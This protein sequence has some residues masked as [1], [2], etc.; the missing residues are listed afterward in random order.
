MMFDAKIGMFHLVF[1]NRDDDY[2]TSSYLKTDFLSYLKLNLFNDGFRYLCFINKSSVISS[3][4]DYQM[5]MTGSLTDEMMKEEPEKKGFFWP[6]GSKKDKKPKTEEIKE[7]SYDS[8]TTLDVNKDTLCRYFINLLDRMGDQTGYAVVCPLDIFSACCEYSNELVEALISR[9]KRSNQN[10]IVLTGSVNAADHD[11]M[12]SG[13]ALSDQPRHYSVFHNENLFPNIRNYIRSKTNR[14]GFPILPKLIITYEFLKDAFGER[15][16][17]LNE[18]SYAS[19]CSLVKYSL[20]RKREI[21][22]IGYP[23]DCYAAL[24]YSWYANV[25]FREKYADLQL[26]DNPF[27]EM[28]VIAKAIGDPRFFEN[29]KEV[30][31]KEGV[32]KSRSSAQELADYWSGDRQETAI[33]YDAA[34]MN[35]RLPDIYGYLLNY[36]RNLRRHE[37]ILSASERRDLEEMER[38]FRQ[39]SYSLYEGQFILPHERCGRYQKSIQEL[40]NSLKKEEWNSWDESAM[41]LLYVMFRRCY[42][43]AQETVEDYT[44]EC[45]RVEFEKCIAIIR[46]CVKYSEMIPYETIMAKGICK[47]AERVLCCKDITTVKAYQLPGVFL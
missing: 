4:S 18:L 8:K 3:K 42:E 11:R 1:A 21:P 26:P 13:L 35:D 7:L 22:D 46:E 41:R 10:I 19:I 14:D 25:K 6:F 28:T 37:E 33:L 31:K 39:P 23:S 9:R 43:H 36:R 40:Y 2:Y 24:I 27:R 30:L 16:H 20:L 38:F 47:E 34:M 5:I 17:V 15:M 44:N 45:G 32:R 29:A 12:F